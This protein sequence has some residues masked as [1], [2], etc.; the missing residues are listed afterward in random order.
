MTLLLE[1]GILQRSW[2]Q[3]SRDLSADKFPRLHLTHLLAQRD[4]AA[5]GQQL[6]HVAARGVV[7]DAAHRHLAALGQGHV[8][9]RRGLLGIV[10]KHLVEVP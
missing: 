8:Q 10:E 3:D 6:L 4:A 9:D 1:T 7:R 2:T 5:G